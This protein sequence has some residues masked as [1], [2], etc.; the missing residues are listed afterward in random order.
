MATVSKCPKCGKRRSQYL[1]Y[2]N[3]CMDQQHAESVA[4]AQA[5]VASGTCPKCGA[6]LKRNLALAGWWQCETTMI[7]GPNVCT[8][9]C[10]TA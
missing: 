5:I 8:F 9:Q 2:C 7:G 3:K 1:P 10:F 6:G 4:K